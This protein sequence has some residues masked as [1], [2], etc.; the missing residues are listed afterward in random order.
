MATDAELAARYWDEHIGPGLAADG[1]PE[2]GLAHLREVYIRD[3]VGLEAAMRP[4]RLL[5]E[6]PYV[7]KTG[8]VLSDAEI[9][10]L[11]DEAERGYDVAHLVKRTWKVYRRV[12]VSGS[13]S[14]QAETFLTKQGISRAP[15][16]PGYYNWNWVLEAASGEEAQLLMEDRLENLL[17][18]YGVTYACTKTVLTEVVE[19]GPR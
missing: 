16:E 17:A 12:L 10:A 13:L 19:S 7:T 15:G 14:R 18:P 9:E 8:K 11:S 5:Y 2:D 4:L 3:V 1:V 6:K